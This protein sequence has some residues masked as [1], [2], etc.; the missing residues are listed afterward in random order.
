M[1][2]LK[3]DL[4]ILSDEWLKRLW[5]VMPKNIYKSQ[6]VAVFCLLSVECNRRVDAGTWK[7]TRKDFY[8]TR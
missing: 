2:T 4:E 7:Y 6:Y 5:D 8:F 3:I 1:T